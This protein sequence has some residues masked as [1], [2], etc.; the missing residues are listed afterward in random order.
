MMIVVL[1][2]AP[3]VWPVISEILAGGAVTLMIATWVKSTDSLDELM[4][5][6][7]MPPLTGLPLSIIIRPNTLLASVEGSPEH[8]D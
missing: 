2:N 6:A 4:L 3:P 8:M 5:T 7:L 1:P